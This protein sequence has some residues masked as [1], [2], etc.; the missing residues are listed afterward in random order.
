MASASWLGA[1]VAMAS[2]KF[3]SMVSVLRAALTSVAD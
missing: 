2:A 3:V 1:S